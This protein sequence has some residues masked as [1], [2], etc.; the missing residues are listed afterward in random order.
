MGVAGAQVGFPVGSEA[1]GYR[2]IAASMLC[3]DIYQIID[4]KGLHATSS[5]LLPIVD[6][7]LEKDSLWI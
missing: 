6:S 5:G 4:F 7:Y 3:E 1:R 2:W